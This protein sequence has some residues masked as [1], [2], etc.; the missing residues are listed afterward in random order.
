MRFKRT[1]DINASFVWKNS[2]VEGMKIPEER[3]E[4][5]K[6]LSKEPD[7]YERLSA[8]LGKGLTSNSDIDQR[9]IRHN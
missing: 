5:I 1:Y 9:D 4:A 3:I 7:V 6:K 8:A 2:R